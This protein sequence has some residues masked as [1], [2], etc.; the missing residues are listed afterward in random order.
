MRRQLRPT[1]LAELVGTFHRSVKSANAALVALPQCPSVFGKENHLIADQRAVVPP[2][3]VA[4]WA[5]H[6]IRIWNDRRAHAALSQ[7]GFSAS[8]SWRESCALEMLSK[9]GVNPVRFGTGPS[10]I[11]S[12]SLMI[13]TNHQ[14]AYSAL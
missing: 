2:Q 8:W 11:C 4:L 6:R 5:A 3:P 7:E 9:F 12:C 13:W 10:S 14:S 1:I